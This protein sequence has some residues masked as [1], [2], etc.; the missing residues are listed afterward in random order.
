M[1]EP[2]TGWAWFQTADPGP[3][4]SGDPFASEAELSALAARCFRGRDGERLLDHL[5]ALT[6]KRALG[7]RSSNKELRYL[8]GQRQLVARL[9]ELVKRGLENGAP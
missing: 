7:P 3:L 2:D 8:E 5:R 1:V 4:D 6:L 9:S